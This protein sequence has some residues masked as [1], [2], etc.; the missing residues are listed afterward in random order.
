MDDPRNTDNAWLETVACHFHDED[1][2]SVGQFHLHAGEHTACHLLA[3]FQ[4]Q[5]AYPICL[6]LSGGTLKLTFSQQFLIGKL[7][8]IRD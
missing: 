2:S 3:S 6:T 7:Q 4:T 1:G 5:S 8:C